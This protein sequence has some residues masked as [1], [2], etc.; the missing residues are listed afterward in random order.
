MTPKLLIAGTRGIPA[1]HGGFE[2]FAEALARHLVAQGWEVGVYCQESGAGPIREE[3]WEGIRRIIVPVGVEGSLGSI[4]FDW[5]CCRHGAKAGAAMLVLGYNTAIFNA[6]PRLHGVPVVMNMDGIEWKRDKWSTPARLWFRINEWAGCH[7][8]HHLVADHPEIARHLT[9]NAGA[10][11]IT[12]IPY[13][14]SAG[15]AAQSALPWDLESGRYL[16]VVAR[17]EPENSILEI[18]RGFS[19]RSRTHK[20]VVLGDFNPTRAYHCEVRDAAGPD[21]IFAGAIYER[22]LLAALRKGA[23]L[24]VHGH[25]VGGTNPALVE[26]MAEGCAVLAHDNR[27]N[28]W[29]AGQGAAYFTDSSGLDRALNALLADEVALH[30]MREA[31]R[32]RHLREFTWPQILSTYERLLLAWQHKG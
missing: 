1:R 28:R 12:M 2:T 9:S 27:F 14:A 3:V 18:V 29:V 10:K 16:L 11:K 26:A 31:S 17:P 8:A 21:V 19:K 5:K 25:R 24:Y 13:G 6:W 32:S 7:I 15:V 20:L 30:R 23:A 4:H 22:P